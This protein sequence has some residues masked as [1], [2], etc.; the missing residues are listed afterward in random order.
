V[1]GRHHEQIA[2]WERRW[3]AA[4]GLMSL[5]FVILIAYSLATE[6][7]HI[8][9]TTARGTPETLLATALFTEPGVRVT[10]PGRVQVS[11]VAQA[12]SFLP[13]RVQ[14][15][16]D[17]EVTFYLTARDVLHGWQVERT[18]LNAMVVPGE[19]ATLRYTFKQP[20]TYRVTCNEYCG[21][22]HQGML[23]TIEVV[24]A[25]RFGR[26]DAPAGTA[27]AAPGAAA[28][29]PAIDGGGLYGAN[30]ASCHGVTG[31]GIPGAFPPL[32]SHA[33]DL[34]AAD[35]GYLAAAVLFGLQG[36]ITV[37]GR[38]YNGVMPGWTHLSDAQIVAILNHA[39][40]LGGPA[41]APYEPDEVA[42]VRARS[43]RPAD[44]LELRREV[45]AR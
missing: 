7:A 5:T 43:L 4:S 13:E 6:G 17:A 15:P 29:S 26:S 32:A 37:D 19:I 1:D 27:A 35:R 14:V 22:G 18:T 9:Q 25:V 16:V 34:A 42:G 2:V 8:A 44:V 39:I 38:A 36:P 41:V 10:A 21:I 45:I 28:A 31:A 20:G 3:I 33:A 11:L 24:E 40:G 23:G 30:C 12:F